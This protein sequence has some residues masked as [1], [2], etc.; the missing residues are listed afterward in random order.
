MIKALSLL[1]ISQV[2]ETP[3]EWSKQVFHSLQFRKY[4]SYGDDCFLKMFKISCK[5][6]KWNK[7]C[8]NFFR[9]L[10]NCA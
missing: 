2:L 6:Q 9:Y 5:F 10:G 3:R 4:I 8:E 1:K 7:N